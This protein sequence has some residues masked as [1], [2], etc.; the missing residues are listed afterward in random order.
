MFAPLLSWSWGSPFSVPLLSARSLL[1]HTE[2][3]VIAE[4][5]PARSAVKRKDLFV[6]PV[7]NNRRSSV[8]L[9]PPMLNTVIRFTQKVGAILGA[10]TALSASFAEIPRLCAGLRDGG[11]CDAELTFM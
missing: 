3:P 5:S 7:R 9:S 10:F 2:S 11:I 1:N 4:P 6:N 8:F